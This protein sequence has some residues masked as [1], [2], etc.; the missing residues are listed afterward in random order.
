MRGGEHGCGRDKVRRILR[1]LESAGYLL[2]QQA[3]T[4]TE[5]GDTR[6][7]VAEFLL[8][9]IPLTEKP[10][11]GLSTD[12]QLT[13]N[14]STGSQLTGNPAHTY[15]EI[16]TEQQTTTDREIATDFVVDPDLSTNNNKIAHAPEA[17]PNP[18]LDDDPPAPPAWTERELEIIQAE[19][20]R[21]GL[22][23]L[24]LQSLRSRDPELALGLLYHCGQ[25]RVEDPAGLLVVMLRR[26]DVPAEKHLKRAAYVLDSA[27]G[28][29]PYEEPEPRED[30]AEHNPPDAAPPPAE[31]ITATGEPE[32][33]PEPAAPVGDGLDTVIAGRQLLELWR[34]ALA[35]CRI[36]PDFFAAWFTDCQLSA[37]ANGVLTVRPRDAEAQ[38]RTAAYT[39]LLN[40]NLS[41][42]AGTALRVQWFWPAPN[43]GAVEVKDKLAVGS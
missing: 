27:D 11:T 25:A 30:S 6:F 10:S 18:A 26:K 39:P 33:G 16:C 36:E 3:R 34:S 22:T 29:A 2:R 5:R 14:Q 28:S 12:S 31:S 38:I 24:G 32:R 4:I 13:G 8:T 15:K 42:L 37:Y 21:I 20:D 7:G 17:A 19:I 41:R 23:G 40:V 1:E 43:G 9:E 35:Q